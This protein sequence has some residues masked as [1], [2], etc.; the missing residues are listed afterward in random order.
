MYQKDF[1]LRML[2]MIAE[3]VAG[4]LKLIKKGDFEKASETLDLAFNDVF[5]QDTSFFDNIPPD[6]FINDLLNTHQY[7]PAHFDALS[8]LY[9]ARAELVYAKEESTKCL[10]Y[11]KKALLLGQYVMKQ[12]QTFSLEKQTRNRYIEQRLLDLNR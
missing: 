12:T 9:Y 11:Y 2:E 8:E 4:A 7:T 3:M 5:G 6:D 10:A 1:I